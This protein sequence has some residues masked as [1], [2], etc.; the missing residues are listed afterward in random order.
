M[1]VANGST[2]DARDIAGAGQA[3][4]STATGTVY[5]LDTN[6]VILTID[7]GGADRDVV[8]PAEA[9][10][11]HPFFI[12]NAADAWEM[13]TVKND[14]AATIG[15][16]PR[17]QARW[18]MPDGTNWKTD[19]T[20]T[21]GGMYV[22]LTT[23][24]TSTD[25]DGDSKSTAAKA[26]LDLSAVFGAPPLIKAAQF[27][28]YCRDSGSAG[29]VAEVILAPVNDAGVGLYVACS[30]LAN[31]SLARGSVIVPCDAS[32]DVYVQLVATGATT[33]DVWLEIWGYWI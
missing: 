23:R 30:G 12:C 7:P 29:G 8:L 14:A 4:I 9:A 32:G 20:T 10:A 24:L 15:T 13:L 3:Q 2:I 33:L 25:W 5:L 22:P 26:A 31:D 6:G 16:V 21:V 27:T 17:Y 18:F 28:V 19:Y 1:T 11:N